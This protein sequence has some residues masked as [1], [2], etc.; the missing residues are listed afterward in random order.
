MKIKILLYLLLFLFSRNIYAITETE[1]SNNDINEKLNCLNSKIEKLAALNNSIANT[2]SKLQTQME[3]NALQTVPAGTVV[4][5]AGT[6]IPEGW[7]LCDG[8]F[9]L[10]SQYPNL[11][12]AIGKLYGGYAGYFNIPDYRGLFL[13]GVSGARSD[14][15]ADIDKST[16]VFGE[17]VGSLQLDSLTEKSNLI[18]ANS[19]PTEKKYFLPTSSNQSRLKTNERRLADDSESKKEF[20]PKNIYVYYIIKY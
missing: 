2:M 5:F 4:A 12:Q 17:R 13:R 16:R 1:C 6:N 15:F 14:Q 7:L 9:F 11:Y 8:R 20:R 10:T 19:F 3:S 18:L